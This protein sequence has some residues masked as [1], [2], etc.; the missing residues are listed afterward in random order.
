MFNHNV[1]NKSII[2]FK[3]FYQIEQPINDWNKTDKMYK[4]Q[5]KTMF[6]Y[7]KHVLHIKDIFKSN[8]KEFDP[9]PQ[10]VLETPIWLIQW[11]KLENAI[12]ANEVILHK[13]VMLL[14]AVIVMPLVYVIFKKVI[15]KICRYVCTTDFMLF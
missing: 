6:T 14:L 15:L 3:S 1:V 4:T 9:P 8:K 2:F 5:F 13:C 7:V 10:V 11:S 12:R